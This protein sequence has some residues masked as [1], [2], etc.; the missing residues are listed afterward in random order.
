MKQMIG[1]PSPAGKWLILG[2]VTFGVFVGVMDANIVG[3]AMPQMLGTFG[4]SLDTLT[5]VAVAYTIAS[6]ITMSM[7]AWLSALLGRKRYYLLSFVA[8]IA[9]SVLCGMARSIEVMIVARILQGLAGGGLVPVAQ[10]TILATFS[11]KERG[12]AMGVYI[13]GVL[14]AAAT[15]PILGGW[16]TDTY[17][18]PWIFYVN[19]PFGIMGVGLALWVLVDPPELQRT[20]KRIDGM[21]VALLVIG[22][23][24]LQVVLQ[25][26]GH[27]DWFA[28]SWITMMTIIAAVSLTIFVCWEWRVKEPVINLRVL[29]NIPFSTGVLF[30]FLFGIPF[31]ASPFLL[32]LFLQQLR[33]YPAWES[34]LML[35]PQALAI[36][37][38]APLA[39]RL[40][41]HFDSR[42]LVG[43]GIVLIMLGYWDMAHFNLQVGIMRMLPGLLLTGSGM[44]IMLTVLT[45]ATMRTVPAN[46]LP[47]ASS[48]YNLTRRI[49]G[50]IGYVV[51][52]NQV[53]ER[54]AFH[55][56]RLAEHITPFDPTT[57]QVLKGLTGKFV[58][59]GLPQSIAQH[60]ALQAL[61]STVNRHATMMAF[62]DVF[63][64]MGMLFIISL[65][66]LFWVGRQSRSTHALALPRALQRA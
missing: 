2:T 48:I 20:L 28:S 6:I 33:G 66:L 40:Y 62:N 8:F 56:A 47:M 60:D 13:M 25:R 27:E 19:V 50:N 61:D 46:L 37:I 58:G 9:A 5:W 14:L 39:G 22:L 10:S 30:A 35:L 54:A 17:G 53:A 41:N 63:L 3:V 21:G 18:W 44:A 15:G 36:V 43:G 7:A 32:P 64:L 38:L 65:P 29:T 59:S 45:T 51:V 23:T 31:F 11:E 24:T 42:L 4:V 12:T 26:G 57:T 49:G 1:T 16:L 52:A 55:R 34:G